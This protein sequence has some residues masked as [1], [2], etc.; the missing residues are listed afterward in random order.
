MREVI[1]GC[2][3][4]VE[5][6]RDPTKS[7]NGRVAFDTRIN[8]G[9]CKLSANFSNTSTSITMGEIDTR[10]QAKK[11]IRSNCRRQP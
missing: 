1:K 11:Y 5:V 2:F 3:A 7:R 8:C 4:Q 9:D 6:T 10:M